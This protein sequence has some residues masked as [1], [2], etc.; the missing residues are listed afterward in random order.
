ML[1]I[2]LVVAAVLRLWRLDVG[3][4]GLYRDEASNG[5]DAL[6]VLQGHHAVYFAANNGREPAYIYLTA[7]AIA[8]LGRTV[9][10]LRIAAALVG[11]LTTIPV[12]LLGRSWFGSRVAL[13]AA[14]LWAVTLWPVHLS[15]LGLRAILLPP[16]LALVFWLGTLAYRRGQTWLWLAAG[17]AYGATFYTYLAARF[18]PLLLLLLLSYLLLKRR[19]AIS[20]PAMRRLWPGALWF[21][22]AASLTLVPLAIAAW[23]EP[24]LVV[25]RV[26]QVSIFN[27]AI[28]GQNPLL[29]LLQQAARAL[30]MFLWRGDTILRHN[31]AGRPVFDLLIAAP[32]LIGLLFCLR[33]W[34]QKPFAALLLWVLVML[35]PTVLAEDAP[36]FLRAAGVLPVVLFL[37]ALGLSKLWEWPKLAD[38]LRRG[39]VLFLLLGTLIVTITDY[40][41][42]VRQ[43]DT[44][45]LFES[46]ARELAQQVNAEPAGAAVFVDRRY[47]EGWPSVPFLLSQS[48]AVNWFSPPVVL[49]PPD[50]LPAT[51][52]A[53]PYEG[54]EF[55][56]RA[57]TPPVLVSIEQGAL[58][59]G[60]LEAQPYPLYVRYAAR[61]YDVPAPQVIFDE[62]IA[63]HDATVT[64]MSAQRLQIE[65]FWS[66]RQAISAPPNVF[67]H[68]TERNAV[69]GDA[70]LA[71]SDAP[72]A[73][74]YWPLATWQPGQVV[75]QQQTVTLLEPFD[76][77]RHQIIVGLYDAVTT[78]RLPASTPRGEPLGNSW[79]LSTEPRAHEEN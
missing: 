43:P 27:P 20:R 57:F 11:T 39:L 74:G 34:R 18:T 19:Q 40:V 66:A 14:W 67:V 78:V 59:R 9:V 21:L 45:Y 36:H 13:F 47:R 56:A 41:D 7:L 22:L 75:R 50:M 12:F 4:P 1:L 44:A 23:R 76:L 53:W 38:A 15:R 33:R 37:P 31:P 29:T 52:Y 35:G 25:G 24:A 72:L 6:G 46:A 42:Y 60:D 48:D 51:V 58:A 77:S 17:I 62:R 65:L 64:V 16:L 49:S 30:G 3:P 79:L 8:L 70:P 63:L 69:A 26:G 32:F 2:V 71:Q 73:Q 54:L 61:A 5:L 55:V 28:G 10:A 68:V